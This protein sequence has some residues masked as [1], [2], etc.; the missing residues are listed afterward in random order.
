MTYPRTAIDF[1]EIEMKRIA[2]RIFGVALFITIFS[3][4]LYL[5]LLYNMSGYNDYIACN[6]KSN[7]YP[8]EWFFGV[9]PVVDCQT[10]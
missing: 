5:A 10:H 9:R 2:K 7:I 6:P 4:V 8:I 1:G 3:F